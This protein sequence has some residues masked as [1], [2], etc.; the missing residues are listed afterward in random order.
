MDDFG[1]KLSAVLA[2][3]EADTTGREM[4]IERICE[5]RAFPKHGPQATRRE[6]E[7]AHDATR[8]AY[9]QTALAV[10]EEWGEPYFLGKCTECEDPWQPLG[11]EC[12]CWD[13]GPFAVCVY[14]GQEDNEFPFAVDVAVVRREAFE[15]PHSEPT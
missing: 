13:R 8:L 10:Q 11:F 3:M 14:W 12:A 1:D 9:M 5:S 2:E 6:R 4:L 7:S 15:Q